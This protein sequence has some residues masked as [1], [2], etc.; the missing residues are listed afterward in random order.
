MPEMD[1]F[2]AAREIRRRGITV[3]IVALTAN[4]LTGDRERCL[5]AGMD[6]YLSKPIVETELVRVLQRFIPDVPPIDEE[7]LTTLRDLAGGSDDFIRE[8]AALYLGDA[9]PRIE[10][11]R[12]ALTKSDARALG[13]AAHALKSG[14]GNVGATT[15]HRLCHDLEAAARN[16]ELANAPEIVRDLER[17]YGRVERRLREISSRADA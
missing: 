17:E 12:H 10:A 14:S 2:T 1:G 16:G 5:E 3:P 8:I 15:L 13:D 4:A 6:D 9:P 11:I 7:T